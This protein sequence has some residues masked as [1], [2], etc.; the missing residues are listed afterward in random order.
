MATTSQNISELHSPKLS[1]RNEGK[2]AHQGEDTGEE[3]IKEKRTGAKSKGERK[4]KRQSQN[5]KEIQED[6]K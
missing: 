5:V 1:W 6:R 3:K 4:W 2:L